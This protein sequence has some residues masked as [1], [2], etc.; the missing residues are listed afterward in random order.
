[1]SPRI[2]QLEKP[3]CIINTQKNLKFLLISPNVY[4]RVW[5]T[6][7]S[8]T[9]KAHICLLYRFLPRLMAQVNTLV[10]LLPH[11][12]VP[13]FR[14]TAESLHPLYSVDPQEPVP[15]SLL[16]QIQVLYPIV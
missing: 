7:Y 11:K 14:A 15:A 6:A 9:A 3:D 2:K 13:L 16:R 1:M 12:T 8:P 4:I 5:Q 10:S